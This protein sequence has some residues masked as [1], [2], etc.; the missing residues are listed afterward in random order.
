M[1]PNNQ[2]DSYAWY[3]VLVVPATPLTLLAAA[4]SDDDDKVMCVLVDIC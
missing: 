1:M 2:L 4:A 3:G